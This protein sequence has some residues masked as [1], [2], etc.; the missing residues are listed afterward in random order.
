MT[1]KVIAAIFAVYEC[2]KL[3]NTASFKILIDRTKGAG[4]LENPPQLIQLMADPFFQKVMVI[5]L[6]YM[7]FALVLLFTAYWYFTIVLFT[8]SIAI[9]MLDTTGTKGNLILATGSAIS[10]ALLMTIVLA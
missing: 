5:E 6:A 4:E 1:I 10:L 3:L 2:Y 8:L 9:I 7:I